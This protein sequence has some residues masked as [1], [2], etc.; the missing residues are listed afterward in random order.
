MEDAYPIRTQDEMMH[1]T[2]SVYHH[3]IQER[4]YGLQMSDER[5]AV[6]HALRRAPSRSPSGSPSSSSLFFSLTFALSF[7]GEA[8][9]WFASIK[10]IVVLFLNIIAVSFFGEGKI[11]FSSIKLHSTTS[12]PLCLT[13]EHKMKIFRTRDAYLGLEIKDTTFTHTGYPTEPMMSSNP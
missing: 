11:W 6:P 3:G 4:R 10:L 13:D 7:F 12:P 2:A 9:I 5:H 8:E 1:Q